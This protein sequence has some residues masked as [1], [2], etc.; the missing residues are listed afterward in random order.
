M[1]IRHTVNFRL[2]HPAGSAEERDFLTTGGDTLSAIPGVHD[3]RILRQ[4]S[5]KSDL[6]FQF[7]MVFVDQAAYDAYDA[8]PDHVGFVQSRWVPEVA[9]FQ[10]YDY[11]EL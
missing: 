10:E 6:D 5:A 11:T 3:F 9:Q 1:T 4:V 2:N 8:H 7:S